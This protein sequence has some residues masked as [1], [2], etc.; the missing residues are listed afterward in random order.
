[1]QVKDILPSIP[2]ERIEVR[3]ITPDG[4]DV[5]F[6]FCSWGGKTLSSLDGDSYYLDEKISKFEFDTD[7]NL[8]YW[9]DCKW[10][11]NEGSLNVVVGE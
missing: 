7:G 1:M 6:G 3:C 8:T 2:L 9:L 4:V 10:M 5:L 11:C